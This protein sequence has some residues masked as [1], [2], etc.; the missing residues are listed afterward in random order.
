MLTVRSVELRR[1][2]KRC[3]RKVTNISVEAAASALVRMPDDDTR[4]EALTTMHP[5]LGTGPERQTLAQYFN[6]YAHRNEAE[7][8]M[9]F[10]EPPPE[11]TPTEDDSP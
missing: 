11:P 2:V 6:D 3:M 10:R 9:G 8:I 4:I 7:V 5:K 1:R